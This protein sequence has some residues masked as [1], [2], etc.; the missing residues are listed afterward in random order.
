MDCAQ[1]AA[2][3]AS[4]SEGVTSQGRNDPEVSCARP[5]LHAQER[6][7]HLTD[8]D[9]IVTEDQSGPKAADQKV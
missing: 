6:G 9:L 2:R 3:D 4:T 1:N 8:Q 7:Q 5:M